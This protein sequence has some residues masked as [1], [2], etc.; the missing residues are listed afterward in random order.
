MLLTAFCKVQEEYN[1]E[2]IDDF[3]IL[4]YNEFY[5]DTQNII[6][7]KC[8]DSSLTEDI[9]SETFYLFYKA[10]KE[11]KPM[12][13]Q[14]RN[15]I[16]GY[17]LRIAKNIHIN[18]F[19]KKQR[20]PQLLELKE[21]Y[22]APIPNQSED[23]DFW[24]D[25]EV[26]TKDLPPQIKQIFKLLNDGYSKKEI[27]DQLNEKPATIRKKVSRAKDALKKRIKKE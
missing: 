25:W 12:R 8:K 4:C 22:D 17:L 9:I 26:Q 2:A 1:L 13:F 14:H 3:T 20:L 27:A 15:E 18:H 11:K 6:Y 21:V 7:S 24:M 19:R 5:N 10:L 16:L 23:I